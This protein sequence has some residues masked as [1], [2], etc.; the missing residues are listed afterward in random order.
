MT[1]F[2]AGEPAAAQTTTGDSFQWAGRMPAGATLRIFTVDG[3]IG[4]TPATGD[5]ADVHGEQRDRS[6]GRSLVFQMI[7]DGDNVTVCAFDPDE[8]S[9][10]SSGAS[11]GSHH[12]HWE[13]TAR[14]FFTVKIPPGVRLDTRTGDGRIDIRGAPGGAE[15][16]ASSGDGDIRIADAT[17]PVDASSGDG[18]IEIATS[19]GPVNA[20]TG[21]GQVEVRV[22]SLPHPQDM[23][24]HTGD[25]SITLYLPSNFAGELDAHT[26]DGHIDSDFPLNVSGRLDSGRIRATLGSGGTTRLELST[27]DGDVHLRQ[28]R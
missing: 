9:C 24:I 15:V 6:G 3:E 10:S 26:G 20:K 13:R 17:G 28:S 11:N 21:D 14:G 18:R 5:Q 23:R 25:G 27:G 12:G 16:V 2:V 22:G 7:K 19:V 8:G 1:A 4:V